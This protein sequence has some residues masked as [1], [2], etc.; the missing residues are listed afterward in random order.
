MIANA[1]ASSTHAHVSSFTE[2]D[3]ARSNGEILSDEVYIQC[4]TDVSV[5]HLMCQLMKYKYQAIKQLRQQ[6]MMQTE[7]NAAQR[8]TSAPKTKWL[9]AKATSRKRR[10]F[11]LFW[12]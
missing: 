4:T 3:K 1:F 8:L 9:I 5:T 11:M 2:R 7:A 10:C 12:V 6:H